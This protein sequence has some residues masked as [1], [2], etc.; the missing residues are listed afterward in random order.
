MT[1]LRLF[2]LGCLAVIGLLIP[3]QHGHAA[4]T[5]DFAD[6][7]G[8]WV[9]RYEYDMNSPAGVQ[10]VVA[11]AAS[12]GITD[13]MFQVRANGD[14]YYNSNVEPRAERLNGSWDPL[15]TAIDAADLYG[16]NVHAWINTIPLW[17]GTAGPVDPSHSFYNTNPSFRLYDINGIPEDPENPYS[18]GYAAANPILPQVHTHI[19]NV[20]ADIINNY[21]VD[22]VHLDYAR[23]LSSLDF[24]TL[25][26]DAI[27]HAMFQYTTGLDGSNPANKDA[28]LGY[29]RDRIT[30]LVGDVHTT[31]ETADPSVKLSAAVWNDP[32]TAYEDRLQDYRAWLEND[33]LDIV[34]PMTYYSEENNMLFPSK[35]EKILAINT[36]ALVAPGIGLFRHNDNPDVAVSQLSSAHVRGANGSTLFS[37]SD[38]FA[39]GQ[40]GVDLRNAVKGFIDSTAQPPVPPPVSG[41]I[42]SLVDFEA[43]EGTFD[44]SPTYSGTNEGI[45]SG[46]AVRDISESY[47]GNASQRIDIVGEADGWELR[48]VS[49]AANPVN[50]VVLTADGWIGFWLMTT[51]TGLTVQLGLDDPSSADRAS[52]RD[53]IAD[54]QWHLYQWDLDNPA[55]WEGWV[56]GTGLIEGPTLT[57]DAIFFHGAGNATF[58]LDA[59]AYNYTGSLIPLITG[60]LNADGFVG[61]EDLNLVLG[62]WNQLVTAGDATAGD[63]TGDGFVGI[64]DLNLVLGNWNAGTPP[65]VNTIPEPASAA[66][67]LLATACLIRRRR[68]R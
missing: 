8:L 43:D 16:M 3:P 7:R 50:N 67:F 44:R 4:G 62:N 40:Q 26:H 68:T 18:T 30:D 23:W 28:Y 58:F 51:D 1:D 32:D 34:M 48:H 52:P 53:V 60:D 12:L 59:V 64:E 13:L 20:V 35:I 56:T 29:I 2:Y 65:G 5:G 27:S 10:Q 54:G 49:G 63:P 14:A 31:A 46:T 57:M 24:D 39:N 36:N 25:P 66:T 45:L 61:I 19:N 22:G 17:R 21:D 37:Y 38:L 33:Y 9:S 41:T 11:N 15:Q 55:H 47:D 6:F 42:V